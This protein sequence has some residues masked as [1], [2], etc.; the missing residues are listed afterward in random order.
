MYGREQRVLVC[1][2][3]LSESR[4][5]R[6]PR[7]RPQIFRAPIPN[8]GLGDLWPWPIRSAPPR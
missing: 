4:A 5:Q 2:H 3:F 8:I 6:D 1:V 7:R